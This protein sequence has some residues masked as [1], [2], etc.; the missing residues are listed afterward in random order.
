MIRSS[1]ESGL[2]IEI[3]AEINDYLITG[4]AG[5]GSNAV[6]FR[7]QHKDTGQEV[8]VKVGVANSAN[9]REIAILSGMNHPNILALYDTLKWGNFLIMVLEYCPYGDLLSAIMDGA[10]A[11]PLAAKLV[12][13]QILSAVEYL[14]ERGIAHGD[15]KPENI[16][17]GADGRPKL[18]DFG[19]SHMTRT[20]GGNEKA[21]TL[22]YAAPELLA[23]GE[24]DTQKADIWALGITYFAMLTGQFPFAAGN[25]AFTRRQIIRRK[26]AW[27]LELDSDSRSLIETMLVP[28]EDRPTAQELFANEYFDVF[29]KA[30]E[31]TLDMSILN[32]PVPVA[33]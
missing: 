13:A 6:V 1:T 15:I 29:G 30:S 18:C 9:A 5:K 22:F 14:H 17:I 23:D 31:S 26:F 27:P 8:A 28:E 21:G 16:L 19:C 32:V 12:F 10:F 11:D 2:V 33:V 25:D 20:G 3:P 7:A 24:F 4:L